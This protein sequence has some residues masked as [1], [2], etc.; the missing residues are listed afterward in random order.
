MRLIVSLF[1]CPLAFHLSAAFMV[2]LRARTQS[3][4]LNVC[5]FYKGSGY[6]KAG[7]VIE[8]SCGGC[9]QTHDEGGA[10]K[11]RHE[12]QRGEEE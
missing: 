3:A 8:Q 9:A 4:F 11:M 7:R 2:S 6:I 1:P 5:G 12:R 10:V